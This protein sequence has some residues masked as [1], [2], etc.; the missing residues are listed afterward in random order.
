MDD[1]L[2]ANGTT[3]RAR[4]IAG[5]IKDQFD[6]TV[7]T[8]SNED[9]NIA[10]LEKI[11][12][13]AIK[14]EKTKLWNLKLIPFIIKTDFDIVYCSND[15]FGFLTYY[16]ISKVLGYKIIFEAHAIL[17]EEHGDSG[18]S[19]IKFIFYK[20]LERFVTTHANHVI[21]LSKDIFCFYREYNE[22]INLIPLFINEIVF[23]RRNQYLSHENAFDKNKKIGLIGPFYEGSNRGFLEFIYE[24]L[25]KFDDRINFIIIGRCDTR[26]NNKRVEY[27]GY[28]DSTTDYVTQLSRLDAVLVH[29]VY[30]ITGP[31][32]KV[33]ESMSC[34][35]PVFTTPKA[36]VGLEFAKNS[37][38]ILVFDENEL[39]D[40]I[41]E[42]IFDDEL[43][44]KIGRNARI[45]I[46]NFYSKKSNKIKLLDIIE[47]LL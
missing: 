21:A 26:I 16:I 45:L 23:Q 11:S 28:L 42:M 38:D 31:Y 43:M 4:E 3:V 41:N 29:R 40:R 30:A 33:M 19:E 34:S 9:Y 37:E 12:I 35:L 10:E 20:F 22:N 17:S 13:I 6:T 2:R 8:R 5:I 15:W 39:I 46:E 44:Q 32:T 27:T 18:C 7:F 36:M 14:P 25:N 24:N 47:N 1:I